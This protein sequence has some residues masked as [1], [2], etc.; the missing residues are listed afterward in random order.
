MDFSKCFDSVPCEWLVMKLQKYG[1]TGRLWRWA[2]DFLRGR[3][4]QVSVRGCLSEVAAVLSGIPQGRILRPLLFI[5]F[6]KIPG[7]V[8]LSI[9]MY[10][11]DTKLYTE[12]QD[13]SN[14]TSQQSD[15]DRLQEWAKAWHLSFNLEKYKVLHL[16]QTNQHASYH[17]ITKICKNIELQNT[18]LEKDLGVWVDPT[19]PS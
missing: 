8:H 14:F 15:L 5:I 2:G 16:R 6:V 10:A 1:I 13:D 12:I 11:E 18:K 9:Q 4:Q 19:S 3:R 17:M 7:M